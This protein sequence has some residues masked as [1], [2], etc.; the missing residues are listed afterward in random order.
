MF[1]PV[2]RTLTP[3]LFILRGV[4]VSHFDIGYRNVA[5]VVKLCR[6]NRVL[7]QKNANFVA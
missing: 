3:A 2:L 6:D 4:N 7:L 1:A 5:V